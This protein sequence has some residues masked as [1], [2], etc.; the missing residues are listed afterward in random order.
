[1]LLSEAFEQVISILLNGDAV[2]SP[3]IQSI[4]S[5]GFPETLILPVSFPDNIGVLSQP[6][7]FQVLRIP[8][9]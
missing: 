4:D 5:V 6:I 1:M 2:T 8:N 3:N 9:R 7:K